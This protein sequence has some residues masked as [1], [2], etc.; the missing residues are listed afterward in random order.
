[1]MP[2]INFTEK[3]VQKLNIY[4]LVGASGVR[5]A[6][7]AIVLRTKGFVSVVCSIVLSV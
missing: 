1:M 7:F 4:T 2:A 3:V 5:T 6:L